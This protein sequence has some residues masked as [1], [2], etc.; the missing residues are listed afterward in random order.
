MGPSEQDNT[1]SSPEEKPLEQPQERAVQP[2]QAPPVA[3]QE[4][5]GALPAQPSMS[6]GPTQQPPV[7]P[8]R[9]SRKGLIIGLIVAAVLVIGLAAAGVVYAFVYNSPDNAVMDAFTKALSAKSGSVA[10]TATMKSDGTTVKFD[11][12][13]ASNASQQTAADVTLTV[14]GQDQKDYK[15][16]GHFAGTKDTVYVKLDDVRS[17]LS[18]ALGSDYAAVFDQYYGS[19]LD[20]I[21]GKWIVLKNSDLAGASSGAVTSTETQCIQS[22]VTKLQSDATVRNEVMN[23]YQKNP[24]FTIA[25]K[26]SD[27]DGN[28]YSLTP[29]SKDRANAFVKAFVE[30]K[31]FKALDGCTSQDLKSSLESSDSSSTSSTDATTG[32]IDVWV[33]G[34]SHNLNKI[35]VNLKS[36]TTELSGEFKPKFNN[37]PSVTIPKGD[38]TFDDLKTEIQSIED[39]FVSSYTTPTSVSNY[40]Y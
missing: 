22:E 18:N 8:V 17:V 15:L 25:S 9:K 30:T 33:D 26:G 13:S 21:D 1:T 32:S 40:A 16:T 11:V 31:F 7:L 34:W 6:G 37:N 29:V 3:V 2:Q 24:L 5:E 38:T 20:K 35:S 28:H 27:S 14:T 4:P 39:Q 19:L 12:T 10:G 23:V 36:S